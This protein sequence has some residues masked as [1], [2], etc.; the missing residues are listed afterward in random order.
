MEMIIGL[1]HFFRKFE[2][3]LYE[4]DASDVELKHDFT[5]PAPKLDSKGVRTR[6]VGIEE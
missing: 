2:F 4:T 6:V 3:E 5:L 1:A